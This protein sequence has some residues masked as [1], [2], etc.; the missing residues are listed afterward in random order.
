MASKRD[1]IRMTAPELRA[2]LDEQRIV[3]VAT[4]GPNG[5]P[6]LMPLWYVV[7]DGDSDPVLRGWTFAKSQKTKNLERDAHATISIDDGVQ[8]QDLRGVMMECDVEVARD[9][10]AVVP[11]GMALFERYGP[12]GE[13]A[14]EVREMV[15]KQAQ[16]RVGLRFVPTRVVTWDHRKLGGGY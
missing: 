14:P 15:L 5:R 9:P 2:F 8:Y 11:Y 1:L 12:G 16:K 3:Q 13:L 10:E 4:I 7:E 6:H